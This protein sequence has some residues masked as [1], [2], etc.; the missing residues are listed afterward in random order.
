MGELFSANIRYSELHLAT[1]LL[2]ILCFFTILATPIYI[3]YPWIL[4]LIPQIIPSKKLRNLNIY[5]SYQLKNNLTPDLGA[6]V[7]G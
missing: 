2:K 6:L 3:N 5:L 4:H 7:G 1:F